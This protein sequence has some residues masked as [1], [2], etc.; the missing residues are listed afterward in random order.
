M[1]IRGDFVTNSSSTDYVVLHASTE[2]GR[3]FEQEIQGIKIPFP[4]CPKKTYFSAMYLQSM[5]ELIGFLNFVFFR[6]ELEFTREMYIQVEESS[7]AEAAEYMDFIQYSDLHR[8]FEDPAGHGDSWRRFLAELK[9]SAARIDQIREI[10]IS[11]N[12]VYWGEMVCL[13]EG[14]EPV[15]DEESNISV[16]LDLEKR[17]VT[18]LERQSAILENGEESEHIVRTT[19]DANTNTI[20]RQSEDND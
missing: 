19:Y 7:P 1:K 2:N 17:I 11:S 15:T 12:D 14:S 5:E 3:S 18:Y 13:Y 8:D 10:R 16:T 6:E 4:T 20:H 9:K